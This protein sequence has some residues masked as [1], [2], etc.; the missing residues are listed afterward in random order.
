MPKAAQLALSAAYSWRTPSRRSPPIQKIA[1]VEGL[2]QALAQRNGLARLPGLRRLAAGYAPA[3]KDSC[4]MRQAT[5]RQPA[6]VCEVTQPVTE[7]LLAKPSDPGTVAGV[8]RSC[9]PRQQGVIRSS[10]P[11]WRAWRTGRRLAP[12]V[13]LHWPLAQ[14]RSRRARAG[15]GNSNWPPTAGDRASHQLRRGGPSSV[16]R[17]CAAW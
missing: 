9:R 3:T 10:E 15:L 14:V 5:G 11:W 16:R 4:T 2:E 8:F 12:P 17:R 6:A 1:A 13:E 7:A